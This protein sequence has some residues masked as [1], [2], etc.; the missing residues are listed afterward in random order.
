MRI[1]WALACR[2]AEGTAGGVDIY[3]AELDTLRVSDLP[4]PTLLPVVARVAALEIESGLDLEHR[5]EGYLL[6]PGMSVLQS[7]EFGLTMEAAPEHP[8]GYEV[9]IVMPLI[10]L[11]VARQDGNH[12]LE[13]RLDG[14]FQWL[15]SFFVRAETPPG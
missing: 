4:A 7:L 6:G 15:V 10:V 5:I 13:L 12:G 3:G 8:A 9:T 14:K 1:E 11:F 2:H